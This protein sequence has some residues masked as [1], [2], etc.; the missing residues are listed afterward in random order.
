VEETRSLV[1][2][3]LDWQI[4]VNTPDSVIEALTIEGRYQNSF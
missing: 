1:E 4:V 3:Y 2:D